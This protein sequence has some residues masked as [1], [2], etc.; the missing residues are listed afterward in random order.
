[1]VATTTMTSV[2]HSTLISQREWIVDI[3]QEIILN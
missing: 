2:F 1:V 3:Y